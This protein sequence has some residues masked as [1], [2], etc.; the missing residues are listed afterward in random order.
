MNFHQF[1]EHKFDAAVKTATRLS[2]KSVVDTSKY[3]WKSK[4]TGISVLGTGTV[5]GTG[6]GTGVATLTCGEVLAGIVATGVISSAIIPA[7][8]ITVGGIVVGISGYILMYRSVSK[9]RKYR[10][11]NKL[12]KVVEILNVEGQ[13]PTFNNNAKELARNTI[14]K[15]NERISELETAL[16]NKPQSLINKG[17]SGTTHVVAVVITVIPKLLWKTCVLIGK[18]VKHIFK[19]SKTET[20]NVVTPEVVTAV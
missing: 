19:K 10:R 6:I 18:S 5:L 14:D 13:D 16:K 9:G 8:G 17:I 20:S 7:V 4:L 15:A 2:E 12:R 1:D 11:L 3:K